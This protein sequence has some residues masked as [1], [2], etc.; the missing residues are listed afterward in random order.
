M[1][2]A[3]A[4]EAQPSIEGVTQRI[5]ES[6]RSCDNV[7]MPASRHAIASA[8][9]ALLLAGCVG[10]PRQA[11]PDP[12]AAPFPVAAFFVGATEGEGTLRI[13]TRSP[14]SI[15]VSSTGR[16]APDGT[17]TVEQQIAEQ[18]RRPR[19]RS[20]HLREVA[21]GRLAG[22]LTDAAG[23]VTGEIRPG[24]LTLSF[25]MKDGMQAHQRLVLAP[26]GQSAHNVLT[27]SRFGLP[28]AVL[29]ETIRRVDD[30]PARTP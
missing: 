12:Q 21:P 24:E 30:Q 13:V 27:V 15:R 28:L 11:E 3:P 25:R 14:R 4:V 20:W 17:I 23:P 8:A 6:R 5:A 29:D 7:A 9:P 22:E 10:L 1:P 18:G 2:P 19:M 26:D 16:V